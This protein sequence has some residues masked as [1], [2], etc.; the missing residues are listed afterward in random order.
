MSNEKYLS[1]NTLGWQSLYKL[2]PKYEMGD[3]ALGFLAKRHFKSA[4]EHFEKALRA[5]E[6]GWESWWGL[7]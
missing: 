1:E 7:A 2:F 6:S 3:Q 4:Q 5:N